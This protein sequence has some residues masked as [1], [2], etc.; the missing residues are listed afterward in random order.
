M[1]KNAI[2]R[3]L[4]VDMVEYLAH[5]EVQGIDAELWNAQKLFC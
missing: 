2:T 3:Y 1:G 4:E 5:P